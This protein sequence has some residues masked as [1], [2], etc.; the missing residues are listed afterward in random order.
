[1]PTPPSLTP[2]EHLRQADAWLLRATHAMGGDATAAH[3]GETF[4]IE[5]YRR[6]ELYAT[7][8]GLHYRAAEVKS[9]AVCYIPGCECGLPGGAR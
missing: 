6:V 4:E 1:M 8:A 3:G 5:S 9:G 2:A 7:M